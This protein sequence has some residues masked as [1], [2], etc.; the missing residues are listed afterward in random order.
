MRFAQLDP[1]ISD[2]IGSDTKVIYMRDVRERVSNIAPF[3]EFDS[4]V[5]PVV[6]DGRIFHVI[7]AYTTTD[8]Y[9]YSQQA[10]VGG[11]P[12]NADLRTV[13]AN[14]IRNSVKAVV[15][16]YSGE[17][18]LYVMPTGDPII[19]SW[20]SAF[21]DLFT[22]FDD[23]PDE[24]RRHLRFPHDMFTV[25]TNMWASYQVSEPEALII[26]TELWA[27]AQDPGRSVSA[28]GPAEAVVDEESGLITRRERRVQAYYSLIQLPGEDEASFVVL[29]SFVPVSEDDSRKELTAFMVGETDSDGIS[30]LVSYEMSNLLAPGPAIVA[31]NIS[32]NPAISREL[33]LLND[34]GSSVDFGDLLLLPVDDS[35]LYIRP[36]Y[37]RAK[38]TQIPLLAGV[39]AAVGDRTALGDTLGDALRKLYPGEDF[40]GVALHP[41]MVDGGDR[42][43]DTADDDGAAGYDDEP[44]GD[45]DSTATGGD[46][47]ADSGVSDSEELLAGLEELRRRD[48][49]AADEVTELIARLLD[50]LSGQPETSGSF[51]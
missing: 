42:A 10:D 39:I 37:V 16:S 18:T 29:R 5:Y 36:L 50:L 43:D 12:F 48:P 23:M 33:T 31:S 14:Y 25:Q 20:R 34:Q 47:S 1:L 46:G 19:E 44:G 3:L 4:D 11:L 32:T 7:D 9:P 24:L 8:R 15:D 51:G 27:V 28:G 2:Y 6:H 30:R 38:G 45:A 49:E 17:V 41:V 21:P 35:M 40:S 26:G 13:G 22:D